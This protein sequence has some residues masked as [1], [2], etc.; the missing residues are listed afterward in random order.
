MNFLLKF[1]WV[2]TDFKL[3]GCRHAL[4]F[5]FFACSLIQLIPVF[6]QQKLPT[7]KQHWTGYHRSRQC[8]FVW[9]TVTLSDEWTQDATAH[10]LQYWTQTLATRHETTS[11]LTT[12]DTVQATVGAISCFVLNCERRNWL[13]FRVLLEKSW[14]HKPSENTC[15][16]VNHNQTI[17]WEALCG[18]FCTQSA[19]GVFASLCERENRAYNTLVSHQK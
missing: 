9:Q 6:L 4:P 5:T 19:F 12:L 3:W 17:H 8:T 2:E 14:T 1:C 16:P 10:R 18:G 11:P 15:C 7:E 13:Q